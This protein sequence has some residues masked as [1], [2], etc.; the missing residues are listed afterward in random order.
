MHTCSLLFRKNMLKYNNEWLPLC[1]KQC[2]SMHGAVI[3]KGKEMLNRN[4]SYNNIWNQKALIFVSC[5]HG[6]KTKTQGKYI[7][8]INCYFEWKCIRYQVKKANEN[9]CQ[10][11]VLLVMVEHE[12]HC[13][14][15]YT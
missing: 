4:L 1:I 13:S 14:I 8:K 9:G 12:V 15:Y 7:A 10:D 5:S 11:N 6:S 3:K 2:K